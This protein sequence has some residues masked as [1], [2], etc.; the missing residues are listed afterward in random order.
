LVLRLSRTAIG[1]A[2]SM[3]FSQRRDHSASCRPPHATIAG[4]QSPGGSRDLEPVGWYRWAIRRGGFVLAR[5]VSRAQRSAAEA[6]EMGKT[7]DRSGLWRS[8]ISGA[9][10]APS[11]P[12]I[13]FAI[14]DRC[15]APHPG[16]ERPS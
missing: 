8:R 9:P 1:E 3:G 11:W 4:A 13:C 6:V 15:A 2:A 5:C 7:R 10:R 16:R 14:F 12:Y